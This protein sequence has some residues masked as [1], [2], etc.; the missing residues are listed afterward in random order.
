[1]TEII[2]VKWSIGAHTGFGGNICKCLAESINSGMYAT[3]FF[4]GSPQSFKRHVVSLE[5]ILESKK[6][7]TRFPMHVFSHF[8]YVV[9]LA[10]SVKSLAWSGD[11][12]QDEKTKNVL[13]N[14]EYE[15]SVLSNFDTLRNGVVI[16]PG[17]YPDRKEGLGAIS[18]SINKIKFTKNSKLLL[19][20]CAGEGNKLAKDFTEIKTIIDGVDKD[21]QDN[22]GV[23]VDTA[24][25]WGVGDYDL[26]LCSEIDKMFRDFEEKI[27]LE[28][29]TLLHLNDS[30]VP[31]GAKKDLHADLGTG[32]IWNK[33]FDSLVYLLN[34]CEKQGI[35]MILETCIGDMKTV[36][37]L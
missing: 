33:G 29:F 34:K 3:Q 36:N 32:H 24:H 30:K 19:E 8:P 31:I 6:L 16:H 14:L 23:C 4:L 26:R 5:D 37:R 20:N 35:P 28:K 27:G 22:I 12:S 7:L 9:N 15:L 2:N 21:K 11:T 17:A 10:G 18:K 25:I 13:K 1:M